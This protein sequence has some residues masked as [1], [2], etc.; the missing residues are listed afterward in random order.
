MTPVAA[1]HGVRSPRASDPGGYDM[2]AWALDHPAPAAEHSLRLVERDVPEPGPN[3]I[4]VKVH[5]CG[6][7]RTDLHLVEGDLSPRRPGVVPG[8]EVVGHVAHRAG[9]RDASQRASAS[10][11]R[12]CA[13]TC[14]VC[15]FCVRG[16]ENLCTAP[17][18]G[19]GRRRRLRRVRGRGR[20]YAYRIPDVFSDFASRPL[21]LR[22]HHRLPRSAAH[23]PAAGRPARHLRLRR[24]GAPDGPGGPSR[25]RDRARH[26]EGADARE[27]A[28]SLGCASAQGADDPPPEPLDAAILFAPVGTLVLPAMA[29]LDRGGRLA[30]AGIHLSD[31]PTLNYDAY[32]FEERELVSVTANTRRDGEEFLALAAEIPIRPTTTEYPF[33]KAADALEDLA[34]RRRERCRGDPRTGRSLSPARRTSRGTAPRRF[35]ACP[36]ARTPRHLPRARTGTGHATTVSPSLVREGPKNS[37]PAYEATMS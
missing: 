17:L 3:E 33:E 25:G 14:G 16:D 29:A 28:L 18:H 8:H 21:A 35:R 20:A 2:R 26:D 23:G 37:V 4:L 30:I 22:R 27:L 24:F 5:A 13:S 6:V 31:V 10:G 7:C 15:R 11:S 1:G 34:R 19:L 36:G 32:L 9:A 12:G